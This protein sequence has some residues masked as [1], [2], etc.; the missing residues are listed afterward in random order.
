MSS[1]PARTTP[2]R[3]E[4]DWDGP[5]VAA[6]GHLL[7]S[8]RWGAFKAL[9]GWEV[10][11]VRAETHAGTA[12]AQVLFRRRGPVSL[13]YLPRGPAFA[14]DDPALA[15]RLFA[16]VD[17]V[18]RRRRAIN[19]IV[20]PDRP[21]PFVG[22][23]R[24][25][26]F[27]RGGEHIQPG[28]TVKVPLL[29]DEALLNQMHQKTRY[30]VRLA[31]RR[32]VVAVRA[33]PD[34]AAV[35]TFYGLLGDTAGRNEFGIHDR[36]YYDDFL[37]LFG[38]DAVLLFALIEEEPVAGVIAARFGDEAVYM[39]GGS[40]TT[41][42]A[43]GAGFYLQFEA[44][45]WAREQGCARYDLWGIPMRDPASTGDGGDRVAGTKGSDWRGLYEFKVRFGGE[46]VSYP[47]ALERRYWPVLAAAG[48]LIYRPGA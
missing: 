28:R 3:E 26:G 46:I 16:E 29:E 25:A 15:E 19:L 37:R 11:R 22:R 10:E 35:A 4:L 13:G 24:D 30:N 45:R 44:M 38:P 17:R 41:Q 14:A 1:A 21:L 27:V 36:R 34:E 8:W 33:E 5:L 18:G 12:Q 47:P 32:G 7:Q 40:S 39:Y 20:E 43:H 6:G 2:P 31:K 48:R 9:H 23:Y 42:R